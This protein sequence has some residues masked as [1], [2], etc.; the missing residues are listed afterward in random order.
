MRLANPFIPPIPDIG[1][2]IPLPG[3]L[4]GP[5]PLNP[6]LPNIDTRSSRGL[7]EV[8]E[9]KDAAAGVFAK[10][11]VAAKPTGALREAESESSKSSRFSAC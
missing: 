4:V 5:G 1:L 2:V 6:T 8:P 11:A 3:L 10:S 7:A 9:I